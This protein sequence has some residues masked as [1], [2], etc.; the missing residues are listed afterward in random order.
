MGLSC[1]SKP[2][3]VEAPG[4]GEPEDPF[5]LHYSLDD[6][7]SLH[8]L[9]ASFTASQNGESLLVQ[10]LIERSVSQVGEP[11]DE[12]VIRLF[13]LIE[14]GVPLNTADETRFAFTAG[15]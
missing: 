8:A 14:A 15:R 7:R 4:P 13:Q 2:A 6:A 5:Q 10:E 3:V 11:E 1:L 12:A 9:S